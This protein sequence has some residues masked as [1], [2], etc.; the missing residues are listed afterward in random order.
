MTMKVAAVATI[1]CI[2]MPGY[3]NSMTPEN[4]PS[5]APSKTA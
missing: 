3:M 2:T 1:A 5:M 4:A